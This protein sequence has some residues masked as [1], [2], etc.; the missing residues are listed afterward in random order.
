MALTVLE[1]RETLHIALTDPIALLTL[2]TLRA[3]GL[4]GPTGSTSV[5]SLAPWLESTALCNV[6]LLNRTYAKSLLRERPIGSCVGRRCTS[7]AAAA[8][9]RRS[10]CV[11]VGACDAAVRYS[12][13][14]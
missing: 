13:C 3:G 12:S 1:S 6:A 9:R 10:A 4:D 11:D 2:S 8:R 7:A 14:V 5:V